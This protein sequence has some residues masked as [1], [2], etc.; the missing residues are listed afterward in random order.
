MDF[1][2][3]VVKS[4][5][6]L[7]KDKLNNPFGNKQAASKDEQPQQ[8]P[9]SDSSKGQAAATEA[10]Q[11]AAAGEVATDNQATDQ[12]GNANSQFA[13]IAADAE[14]VTQKAVK[15]AKDFGSFLFSMANKA[16]QTV[17]QTAKQVKQAVE[18][19][20]IL[21]DLTREQQDFIK[22]HGG[23]MQAG[24]LPWAAC[25]DETK[26]ADIREQVLTLSQDRRNFVRSPPS[27]AD[28][29]FDPQQCYPIALSLM[30]ED[31]NLGKMRFELVPKLVNEDTFW[32][33]YFYRV[34]LLKQMSA[35]GEDIKRQG[36]TS[37]R[38]SSG[39]GPD[40]PTSPGFDSSA[41][42]NTP[43]T[44]AST[45]AT[46]PATTDTSNF[47]RQQPDYSSYNFETGTTTADAND[48]INQEL[49]SSKLF[50]EADDLKSKL[51]ELN[52]GSLD[53]ASETQDG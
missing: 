30:K 52:I 8:Q 11:T 28:Y 47:Q 31:P 44:L 26:A 39:E 50:A 2:D 46:I 42:I 45:T 10:S 41:A 5:N 29:Q 49:E 4:S 14:A 22:E 32:R 24:E 20:S 23:S 38:S 53:D 19:T 7:I 17:S 3:N 18:N 6:A 21:T 16:G 34:H 15:G 1:L 43:A 37:S 51:R 40:E 25:D 12:A 27:D 13:A 9:V 48:L 36:W 33:N 35:R